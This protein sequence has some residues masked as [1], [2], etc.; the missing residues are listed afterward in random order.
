MQGA[1]L[2]DSN[3][4]GAYLS[5]TNLQNAWLD[6]VKMQGIFAS[7][8]Q[9]QGADLENAQL[10]GMFLANVQFQGAKFANTQ[11]QGVTSHRCNFASIRSKENGY[12]EFKDLAGVEADFTGIVLSRLDKQK[13]DKI[14]EEI[15]SITEYKDSFEYTSSRI[16]AAT[17]KDGDSDALSSISQVLTQEEIDKILVDYRN[18]TGTDM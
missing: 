10:Q 17:E 2:S 3:L 13:A 12:V 7:E 4:Q 9:F 11:M 18:S 5:Q 15:Y 14:I 16:Y 8:T 1:I 6:G